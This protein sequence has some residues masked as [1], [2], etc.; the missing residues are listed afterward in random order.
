MS[1]TISSERLE[2]V[3]D[4]FLKVGAGDGTLVDLF[5]EDALIHFPKFGLARGRDGLGAFA[6]RMRTQLASI[7]HHIADFTYVVGDKAIVVEGTEYGSMHDG[8][9]WPDGAVSQGR[10]CSV[11]EFVGLEISRMF[12]YVDPDFCSDD[13]D[14][15]DWLRNEAVAA[16]A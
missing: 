11:F 14:R 7:G 13:A 5:A 3:K 15:I 12:I 4:Y 9:T 6:T 8:R 10:F 16:A 1:A 2:R